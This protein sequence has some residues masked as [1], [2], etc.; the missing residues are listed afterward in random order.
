VSGI[1]VILVVFSLTGIRQDILMC[2]LVY[3]KSCDDIRR[4]FLTL[5]EGYKLEVTLKQKTQESYGSERKHGVT[6][7]SQQGTPSVERLS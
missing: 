6:D 3:F 2:S 5:K 7:S 1:K 4:M